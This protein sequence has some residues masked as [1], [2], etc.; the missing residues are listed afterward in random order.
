[1]LK[2]LEDDG[3]FTWDCPH[4]EATNAA[5]HSHEAVTTMPQAHLDNLVARGLS[6]DEAKRALSHLAGKQIHLPPCS[7]GTQTILKA[8]FTSD[9]LQAPNMKDKQGLP[10]P[11]YFAALRHMQLLQMMQDAG[12][13]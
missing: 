8:D 7:C 5:H 12:K 1:M 11:S 9:D 3:N 13:A 10:T 2:T 6:A 4:C